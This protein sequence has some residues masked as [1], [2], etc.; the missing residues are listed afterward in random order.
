MKANAKN[1]AAEFG[2]IR[3]EGLIGFCGHVISIW[4][5]LAD[6]SAAIDPQHRCISL[7]HQLIHNSPPDSACSQN[8]MHDEARLSL[9]TKSDRGS[10]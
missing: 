9:L 6:A 3:H 5:S 4:Q 8:N 1:L 10:R 2:C 7:L